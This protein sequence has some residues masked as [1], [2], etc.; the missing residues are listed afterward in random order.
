MTPNRLS[1]FTM[2]GVVFKVAKTKRGWHL[3]R[4]ESPEGQRRQG[5]L[6]PALTRFCAMLDRNKIRISC[7]VC[8]DRAAGAVEDYAL[9]RFL[10]R[11]GFCPWRDRGDVYPLELIRLPAGITAAPDVASDYVWRK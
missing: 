5:M 8:A 6:T 2:A 4:I 7:C 9:A 10:S 11:F 1:T 3:E